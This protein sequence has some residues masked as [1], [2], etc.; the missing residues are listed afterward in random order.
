MMFNLNKIV[1][2][3]IRDIKESSNIMGHIW[4]AAAA[5]AVV[6]LAIF[7]ITFSIILGV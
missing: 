5:V 2:E 7:V 3:T 6:F 4:Y 1:N